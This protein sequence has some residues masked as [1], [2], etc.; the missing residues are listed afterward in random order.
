MPAR[1]L[2]VDDD[3]N[4]RT[5]IRRALV[6]NGYDVVECDSGAAALHM[7]SQDDRWDALLLDVD[8]PEMNG[9]ELCA[10]LRASGVIAPVL[11]LTGRDG[12][13]DRVVG[14]DAGADDYIIKSVEL[15]ELLARIRSATRRGQLARMQHE[16]DRHSESQQIGFGSTTLFLDRMELT[17]PS[18]VTLRLSRTEV[19]LLELFFRNPRSVLAKSVIYERVWG[20]DI[21]Y[22]SNSLEVFIS[23]L[24]KKLA[25]AGFPALLHTV[26]GVGYQLRE[27]DNA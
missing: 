7:V 26:R 20:V 22:S 11:M 17:A 25:S 16:D 14:L 12:V 13:G 19:Q 10:Q 9:F 15:P 3:A 1:L 4:Y 8:M 24:R 6:L 21:S 27:G 5:S 2:I 23:T 18:A